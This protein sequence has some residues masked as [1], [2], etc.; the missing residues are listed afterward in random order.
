ML[1]IQI[2]VNSLFRPHPSSSHSNTSLSYSP[3]NSLATAS[4]W[5]GLRQ[6]IYMATLYHRSVQINL[7][8]YVVDRSASPTTDFGWANRAVV[9]C[10]DVLNCCFGAEGVGLGRWEELK[11]GCARWSKETP[12]S[13]TPIFRREG[14]NEKDKGGEEREAFPEIWHSHA[15]HSMW[16]RF[17]RGIEVTNENSNWSSAS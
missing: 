4:F 3:Q 14:G 11:R 9:L 15:C 6:E 10:A 12:S 13:F 8:H 16:F 1:G 17:I 2:F 7:E 5:V